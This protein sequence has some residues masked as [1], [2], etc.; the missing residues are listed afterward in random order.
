METVLHI[1]LDDTDS[2]ERGCTTYIAAV[3]AELLEKEANCVFIDYPNL[4]RLNPNIPWKTRGN[5]ALSLHVRCQERDIEQV[6]NLVVKT[7]EQVSDMD[8]EATEPAVAFLKGPV[9]EALT[10]FSYRAI[11][12]VVPLEDAC[13]VA[14]RLHVETVL[15]K[16]ERGLVGCLAALGEVLKL[17]HTFELIAY[18]TPLRY[19][20]PRKIDVESIKRMDKETSPCTFNNYDYEAGR[21]L[22]TPHGPDPILYGIRGETPQ[23]L[24]KAKG[25]LKVLE[26]IERWSVFRT[27][28]GTDMHLQEVYRLNKIRPHIPVVAQGS[29]IHGPHVI[30]GRHVI[31]TITDGFAEI[32]C[33]AYEPT[34]GFRNVIKALALNDLVQVSGGVRPPCRN[35]PQT[36]NLE[37]IRILKLAPLFRYVNP[38]CPKCGRRTESAGRS[39]GYRCTRCKVEILRK[40]KDSI[41]IPRSV[42]EKLYVTPPKA[43]RHLTK[44]LT[45]YGLEKTNFNP[46]LLRKWH[47]P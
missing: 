43:N 7:V 46:T 36:I 3:L 9:P 30:K 23:I 11:R 13:Q 17:D 15:F 25:L 22:I 10:H 6:K 29:V 4:I 5:G 34:G 19:G 35:H 40:E 41:P 2:P 45:R 44:P 1:G 31:F 37:K 42:E 12:D 18:R 38:T 47:E 21:A 27:N 8:G 39:Q 28:H 16:G 24:I 14:Q 26:P 20:T 33:A 32:D